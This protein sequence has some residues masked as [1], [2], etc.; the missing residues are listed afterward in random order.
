MKK[1][2]FVFVLIALTFFAFKSN[3][4]A[5]VINYDSEA[6]KYNVKMAK[7]VSEF[8]PDMGQFN[9]GF[10]ESMSCKELLGSTLVKFIKTV[11][12]TVQGVGVAIAIANGMLTF[13][14]AITSKDASALNKA[15]AKFVKLLAILALLLLLPTLIN[16]IGNLAGFD[17]SCL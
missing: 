9:P 5:E 8:N 4:E 13:V 6:A 11:R 12:I 14:P 7:E 16:F 10:G 2:M 17:L 1:I 15:F 3:L